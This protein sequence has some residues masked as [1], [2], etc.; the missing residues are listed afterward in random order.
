MKFWKIKN[1][2]SAEDGKEEIENTKK[3]FG[4]ENA[5]KNSKSKQN[6]VANDPFYEEENQLENFIKNE[7]VKN[8]DSSNKTRP[9]QTN[10]VEKKQKRDDSDDDLAGWDA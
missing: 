2:G 10:K 1:Y 8:I 5:K 4:S 3:V 6:V 9:N 7:G